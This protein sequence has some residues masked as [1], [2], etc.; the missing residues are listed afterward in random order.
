MANKVE[1]LLKGGG[2][3]ISNYCDNLAETSLHDKR[4]ATEGKIEMLHR[5][6][7]NFHTVLSA[8]H[9]LHDLRNDT[10]VRDIC[11]TDSVVAFEQCR[12]FFSNL[13]EVD[14]QLS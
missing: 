12:Y 10:I 8:K 4:E 7:P 6:T 11:T 2:T 14:S 1:T 9:G 3:I 13:R 5:T